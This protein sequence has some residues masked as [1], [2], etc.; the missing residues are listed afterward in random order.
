MVFLNKK[1]RKEHILLTW[2]SVVVSPSQPQGGGKSKLFCPPQKQ[3]LKK[4]KP[5]S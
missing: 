1:R 2:L 3:L 5:T 4:T